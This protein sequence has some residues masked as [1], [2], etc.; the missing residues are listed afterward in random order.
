MTSWTAWPIATPRP[1]HCEHLDV[2]A[3]VADRQHVGGVDA[4]LLGDVGEAGGLGDAD[5]GEVEPG[6]P[7]DDVVGAVQ[8]EL[9]G[10]RDEVLGGGLGVADDH[11]AD[12]RGDQVLDLGEDHL[13]GELAVGN[14]WLT[15]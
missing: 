15:R 12:R 6:G 10:Q 3:A 1:A 14:C 7:A 11:P 2:V 5:R 8:A 13:A 4:E 9:R